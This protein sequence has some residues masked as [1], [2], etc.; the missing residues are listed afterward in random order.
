MN[1]SSMLKQVFNVFM[2]IIIFKDK[3]KDGCTIYN[4]PIRMVN[5]SN[6]S[7]EIP[8]LEHREL[9]LRDSYK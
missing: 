2:F 7:W 8:N 3:I 1:L 6:H 4:Y 5:G 9:C